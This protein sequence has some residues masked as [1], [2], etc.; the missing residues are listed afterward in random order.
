MPVPK[1]SLSN[2]LGF[3]DILRYKYGYNSRKKINGFMFSQYNLYKLEINFV[4][5]GYGSLVQI[6]YWAEDVGSLKM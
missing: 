1:V 4:D 5:L 3:L 6:N 2:P